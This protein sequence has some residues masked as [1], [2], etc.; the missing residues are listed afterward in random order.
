MHVPFIV[1][2]A[3]ALVALRFL[4]RPLLAGLY[5]KQ[6]GA[7]VLAKQPVAIHL[8]PADAGAARRPAELESLAQRFTREG[9]SDAGW[10]TVPE[11]PDI[12]LRLLAHE[13]EGWLAAIYD[14]KQRVPWLE[15][16]MRF[17]DGTRMACVNVASTGLAPLP[18]A[19]VHYMPGVSPG[20][21][22]R[23]GRIARAKRDL[24]PLTV[25]ASTA[26]RVFEE[27]YAQL[28]ARRRQKGISRAE[29]VMVTVR[30]PF[31]KGNKAA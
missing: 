16:N 4:L 29:V 21:L 20:M 28:A 27:G 31:A 14:H 7:S 19:D 24:T 15:L 11:M 2:L 6:I 12:V 8:Q 9:F 5:G 23:A 17:P 13:P 25:S 10:F 1:W 18:G 22:L 26:P 3:V 30:R